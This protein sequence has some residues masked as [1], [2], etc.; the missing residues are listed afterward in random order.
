MET[1]VQ[2][3]YLANLFDYPK[4]DYKQ[5]MKMTHRFLD[6]TYESI[7]TPYQHFFDFV[8]ATSL[9]DIEELFSKTFHIQAICFLDLGY[10]LFAE[11]Y[12]R[13]EFL[14]KMKGELEKTGLHPGIELADHLPVV[15]RWMAITHEEEF[16]E[17]FAVRIIIPALRKMLNEFEIARMELKDKVR[18]KKQ[19]VILMEDVENKNI[20]QY[21]IQLL[22]DVILHEFPENNFKDPEFI[23]ALGGDVIKVCSIGCG[24]ADTIEKSN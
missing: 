16:L 6:N 4:E 24:T 15:L 20:F 3:D 2:F 14:V 7:V 11:D 22:L 10:V 17:E 5:K 8:D 1:R 9:F 12:K 21:P 23:P 19:K 18:L 13:G